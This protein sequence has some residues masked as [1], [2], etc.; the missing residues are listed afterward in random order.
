MIN[1]SKIKLI[2]LE[3]HSRIYDFENKFFLLMELESK[4]QIFNKVEFI[5]SSFSVKQTTMKQNR[6]QYCIF[7]LNE[8]KLSKLNYA[9]LDYS[10]AYTSVIMN[11][12]FI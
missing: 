9:E 3:E 5:H 2:S 11:I 4:G 8:L 7:R 10:V 12:L 1:I 6:I